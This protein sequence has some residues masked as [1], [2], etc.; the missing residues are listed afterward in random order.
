MLNILNIITKTLQLSA[1]CCIIIYLLLIL[2]PIK[3]AN[4]DT[5]KNIAITQIVAHDSLDKV[6]NGI[7]DILK[8]KYGDQINIALSN[9]NGNI[10]I[11][12]Q[13][14]EKLVSRK[15]DLIIAITTPS[16]QTV[17][18]SAK[19]TN[20]PILFA[21]VTDPIGAN[22]VSN[23]VK[24]D[25][26]ITGTRNV[27]PIKELLVMI[28]QIIPN[29]KKLGVVLS[30]SEANSAFILKILKEKTKKYSIEIEEKYVINS[31]EVK[32]ATESLVNKVDAFLLLQ[33]NLV[34]SSV[35]SLIKVATKANKSVISSYSEAV[36]YGALASLAFDEYYIGRQTGKMAIRILEG[37][38]PAEIAVEDP[39]RI[40]L[41]LNKKI[42]EK[43]GI[44]LPI[45]LLKNSKL[46]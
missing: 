16:A 31:S 26:N 35:G 32:L 14:A 46:L 2:S 44:N 9:A 22:L 17:L 28:K 6:R 37:A 29:V 7:I 27:S 34:A 1:K 19:K 33:D 20:I 38:K 18:N 4:A 41:I 10:V 39:K 43:L 25:G 13:I 23:L 30:M 21:T 42:T 3:F 24:P 5:I 12:S 40:E 36:K 45:S 11:A 8:E 15:P